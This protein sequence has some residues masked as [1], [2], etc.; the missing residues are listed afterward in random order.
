MYHCIDCS[1]TGYCDKTY[2][3]SLCLCV[4]LNLDVQ[5][6]KFRALNDWFLTPQGQ[7]VQEAISAKI[8]AVKDRLR[9]TTML[10]LG[11][12]GE[13]TWLK[14]LSFRRQWL[15]SPRF[16]DAHASLI[17]SVEMLPF[18][19]ASVDCVI[20]PL[21]MELCAPE[22]RVIYEIDRVLK[23]MGHIIFIGINP[24]SLW[25]LFLKCGFIEHFSS[26]KTTLTSSLSLKH[27]MLNQNYRLNSLETFCYVPPVKSTTALLKLRFLNEI[28]KMIILSPAGFYCLVV[29]KYQYATPKLAAYKKQSRIRI[30]EP[31]SVFNLFH[32]Y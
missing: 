21:T 28:G 26:F 25:G 22:K 14:G 32:R 2:L 20:A 4:I 6:N 9:G 8:L 17:S 29:Q 11:S 15:L 1:G 31:A 18:E 3:I 13:N 12:C 5:Q 16:E 24:I 23:P 27:V 30:Q 7:F 19:R 10:Q